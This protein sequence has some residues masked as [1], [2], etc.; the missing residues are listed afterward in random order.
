MSDALNQDQK[1]GEEESEPTLHAEIRKH[2]GNGVAGV[3]IIARMEAD[4]LLPEI[5]LIAAP[6]EHFNM[7]IATIAS[8]YLA[9]DTAVQNM[10]DNADVPFDAIA[11]MVEAHSIMLKV[12]QSDDPDITHLD[13]DGDIVI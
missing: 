1:E 6:M 7:T 12:H 8:C 4:A 3:A 9:L 13:D 11:L 5:T 2:I 10:A